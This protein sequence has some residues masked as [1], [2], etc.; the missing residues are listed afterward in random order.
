MLFLG[1]KS[2]IAYWIKGVVCYDFKVVEYP[3][4]KEY[5]G[6]DIELLK[7]PCVFGLRVLGAKFVEGIEIEEGNLLLIVD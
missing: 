2:E 6:F 5:K 3:A 4:W 7:F 1:G